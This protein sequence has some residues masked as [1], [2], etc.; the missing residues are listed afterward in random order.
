[1]T[2]LQTGK[3]GKGNKYPEELKAF[4][5]T[6]Q[7]YSAKGYEFVRKTSTFPCLINRKYEDVTLKFQR[8]QV[9]QRKRS[10]HFD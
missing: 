7:F 10:M 8:I 5:L 9:L 2:Q 6:L 3:T 1:M 4:A